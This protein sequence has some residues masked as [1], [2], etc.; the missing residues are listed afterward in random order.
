MTQVLFIPPTWDSGRF[1]DHYVETAKA[2][3]VKAMFV[4]EGIN[5]AVLKQGL[6]LVVAQS[7]SRDAGA[8]VD[9]SWV[10]LDVENTYDV[11]DV[12]HAM[13][14]ELGMHWAA[15]HGSA[16]L[17]N[18]A[19]LVELGARLSSPHDA[20]IWP[21]L[22]LPAAEAVSLDRRRLPGKANPLA[23]Y[24]GM[25][26]PLGVEWT[27]TPCML[28]G[29]NP[30]ALEAGDWIELTGRAQHI[31][32]GP[33]IFLPQGRW[34]ATLSFSVDPDNSL[35]SLFC[36]WGGGAQKMSSCEF[37]IRRPGHYEIAMECELACPDAVHFLFATQTALFSGRA[38]IG[39]LRVRRV[40]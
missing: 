1:R 33:N 22:Q 4:S 8:L 25:R 37:S 14:P 39:E 10:V 24:Q 34:K 20:I 17:A 18:G 38:R 30:E 11:V 19:W 27:W 3:G 26:L 21:N 9:D 28:G 32:N 31:V 29:P 13:H 6:D 40:G 16:G 7:V 5:A 36:E 23:F 35:P 15:T 2:S 12:F